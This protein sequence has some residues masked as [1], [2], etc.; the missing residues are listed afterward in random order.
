M[1]LLFDIGGTHTRFAISS[2]H[3]TLGEVKIIDTPKNYSDV[4]NTYKIIVTELTKGEKLSA[5]CGGVPGVLD[6]QKAM[7]VSAPHLPDWVGKPFKEDLQRTLEAP[8]FLEND[9]ALAGLGEAVFGAGEGKSIVAYLTISTGV[10]G[11]RIVDGQIDKSAYN[12]EPGHQIVD[13]EHLIQ[14]EDLISGTALSNR[15]HQKSEEIHDEQVWNEVAKNLAV[16]LHNTTVYWSPNI[17]VLGGSVSKSLP[18]EK[19]QEYFKEYA[20][21]YPA[22]PEVQKS[23]LVDISGLYGALAHLGSKAS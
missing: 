17:I 1:Y 18:I 10:G 19:A 4:L 5:I 16:G 13:L 9:A 20:S 22:V 15:Y 23:K 8:L 21:L 3:K 14:L 11:A 7:L 6:S 2:D 12:F